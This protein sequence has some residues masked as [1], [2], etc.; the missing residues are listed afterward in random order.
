MP[1]TQ[2]RPKRLARTT[3]YKSAWINLHLDK[4]HFPD[5]RI[6]EEMHV[7]D[8]PAEAVGMIVIN[9]EK[10][11]LLEY[12]YR[13]HTNA[14]GWEIPAGG[15]NQGE[16]I[17]EAGRREVLE[18]TGYD[19]KGHK[20]IYSYNPSNG[21]SNQVLHVVRCTVKE[22]KQVAFD[23]N[24]VREIKWFTEKD[25]GEMIKN[26]EIKDG[27]TLSGLLLHLIKY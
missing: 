10:L 17:L 9:K 7:L 23:K 1:P 25:I 2:K 20:L 14:D 5:G 3:I 11:I 16:S 8:Y 18:E 26:K 6:V 21:S 13:Y 24:E 22:T 4:V 12:A 27:H 15:I 19:T